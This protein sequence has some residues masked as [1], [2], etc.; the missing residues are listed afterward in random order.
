[1][2]KLY[3]FDQTRTLTALGIGASEGAGLRENFG[4]MT[5]PFHAGRAAENGVVAADMARLGWTAADTI[6]E[7]PRGFFQAAGGGFDPNAIMGKLG[8]PWTFVSPGISI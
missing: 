7:A 5:K 4:T 6:L 3:E 8:K 1:M 2:S